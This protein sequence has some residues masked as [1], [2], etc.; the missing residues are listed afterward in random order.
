MDEAVVSA[1]VTDQ[2]NKVAVEVDLITE[3]SSGDPKDQDADASAH[4]EVTKYRD[5]EESTYPELPEY[6]GSDARDHPEVHEDHEV[7]VSGYIY[8][9]N[10]HKTPECVRTMYVDI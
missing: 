2:H 6:L 5:A 9:G 3:G 8:E 4:P 1:A 10:T 7:P